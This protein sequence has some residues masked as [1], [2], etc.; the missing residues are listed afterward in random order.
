MPKTITRAPKGGWL[1]LEPEDCP[2]KDQHTPPPTSYLVFHDW[3]EKKAKTH[4]QMRCAG[5]HRWSVWVPGSE[6]PDE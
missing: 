6:E 5:C 1:Y 3:A 2:L 4:R